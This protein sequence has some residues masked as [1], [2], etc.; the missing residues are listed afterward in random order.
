MAAGVAA[1]AVTGY[2]VY[3]SLDPASKEK[4][5]DLASEQT[6]KISGSVEFLG[7][8][9]KTVG[10]QRGRFED[11]R[12]ILSQRPSSGTSPLHFFSFY[13]KVSIY[14]IQMT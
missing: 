11:L 5:R 8:L 13:N 12:K 4:V 14:I 9:W 7:P 1:A 2:S 6:Q 3:Q 10:D